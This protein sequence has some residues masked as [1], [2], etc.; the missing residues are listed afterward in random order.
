MNVIQFCKPF[1][2][3][4]THFSQ[5][6]LDSFSQPLTATLAKECQIRSPPLKSSKIEKKISKIKN[7]VRG[8]TKRVTKV[9]SRHFGLKRDNNLK[10][11][12]TKDVKLRNPV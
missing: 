1:P 7:W 10:E 2:I 9:I 5:Y 11:L 3:I 4:R 6:T 12:C 8:F